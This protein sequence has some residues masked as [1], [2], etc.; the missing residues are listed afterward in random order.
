MQF[1]FRLACSASLPKHSRQQVAENC[2]EDLQYMRLFS[3]EL[4]VNLRRSYE[5][6]PCKPHYSTKSLKETRLSRALKGSEMRDSDGR[7]EV[8]TEVTAIESFTASLTSSVY[9]FR[10]ENGR[11][12]HAYRDGHYL[13][14]NDED[15]KERLDIM[16]A[17][18]LEMMDGK[19]FLAPISETPRHVLDLGTGTGL[20]AIDFG[21]NF[22]QA[23]IIGNDLSPMQP[24][25][26][27]PKVT[28]IIDD[29]E[30]EWVY[31]GRQFDF[32]HARYL[33]GS[34]RNFPR[35]LEQC[36]NN[37]APGGWVEFQ[38]WNASI[39]SE[40]ES[41]EGSSI[42]LYYDI[43]NAAY[44][45]AGY[46]INPGP[47]LERWFREAGFI[48]VRVRKYL[49]PMGTWPKDERLKVLGA[50]NLLEADSGF[51]AGA[52]AILTRNEG[53]GRDEVKILAQKARSDIRNHNIHSMF[54]FYVVCG[55]KPE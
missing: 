26:V 9:D 30:D 35:L 36:Y 55:R 37:T 53:W 22:P 39:Y 4:P 6:A 17:M 13:M 46:T 32:I 48:D 11:R 24:E 54:D 40:D 3:K 19:L 8:D 42:K 5:I 23:E 49:L 33:A 47:N 52:M 27:P 43:I 45:K 44:A 2:A 16:H 34:V 41:L 25:H 21:D 10:N 31:E 15:E 14:P 50:W 18:M 38:D 20:W 7:V 29:F 28:F 51:E 12:Y 1:N